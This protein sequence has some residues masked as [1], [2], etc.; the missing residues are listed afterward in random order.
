MSPSQRRQRSFPLSRPLG[1]TAY[2]PNR[3]PLPSRRQQRLRWIRWLDPL[4]P[5]HR[6][7][8]P[9]RR[10]RH[11]LSPRHHRRTAL[12]RRRRPRRRLHLRIALLLFSLLSRHRRRTRM[13]SPRLFRRH[14]VRQLRNLALRPMAQGHRSTRQRHHLHRRAEADE[15]RS[16]PSALS[17]SLPLQASQPLC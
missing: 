10:Q 2:R 17:Y 3:L 5:S 9:H 12:L 4:L 13:V 1:L 8:P 16:S 6:L 15:V 14:Q 11:R 7:Q